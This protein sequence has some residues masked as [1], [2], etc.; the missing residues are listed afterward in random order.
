MAMSGNGAQGGPLTGVSVLELGGIGPAP[1]ACMLLS[2]LGAH[3]TRI[4]RLDADMLAGAGDPRYDFLLRGRERVAVDIKSDRGREIALRLVS[5]TSVLV[6]G[7]RPGVAEKLGLGPVECLALNPALV[8]GRM[9]GWGQ[10]GPL[11]STAGHDINYIA[12][13]G[14]LHAI[15]QHDGPPAVP[16]NLLG[17]FGGGAAFLVIG[18]LAALLEAR[19]TGRGQVVDAAMIDGAVSLMTAIYAAF[20][21]GY[22][23]DER[24]SNLLDGGA[25]FYAV[26]ETADGKH[27]AIGAI[28][29]KFFAQLLAKLGF[30]P[31][32]VPPQFEAARWPE[33]RRLLAERFRTKTRDDWSALLEGTDTCFAPVL[34]LGEAAQHP[35]L[36]ARGVFQP[37]AG[38]DQ[39][40]P[41]PRFSRTPSAIARPGVAAGFDTSAVLLRL[42]L[43]EDEIRDLRRSGVVGGS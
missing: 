13:S 16:L 28:E 43:S 6:E 3:V 35:H 37:V 12:L 39:P 19:R 14:A 17:D 25:P 5:G 8:Y 27:V 42:G 31:E 38:I 18:V 29:P 30:S 2:D 15:G 41:A 23:R 11:A 40:A 20:S 21:S 24:E 1:Y 36:R 26:Y 34:T 7:F 32:Q 4:D 22:W 9:T 10:A 33:L